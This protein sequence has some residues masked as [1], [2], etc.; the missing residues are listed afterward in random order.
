MMEK[1][2]EGKY[3]S[4]DE[5]YMDDLF[6]GIL[7]ERMLKGRMEWNIMHSCLHFHVIEL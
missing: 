5:R 4:T 1:D 7:F 2:L 6:K 3:F